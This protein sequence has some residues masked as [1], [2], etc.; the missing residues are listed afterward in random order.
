MALDYNVMAHSNNYTEVYLRIGTL[1]VSVRTFLSESRHNRKDRHVLG[2][3]TT[4]AHLGRNLRAWRPDM[5]IEKSLR[6]FRWD[7]PL[8][9]YNFLAMV[10]TWNFRN[11]YYPPCLFVA[12]FPPVVFSQDL[13][14]VTKIFCHSVSLRAVYTNTRK[15]EWL[16]SHFY[17]R[18]GY[19]RKLRFVQ[20]TNFL[21]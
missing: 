20:Q 6:V 14:V 2:Q 12:V 18:C 11:N 5:R 4:S 10:D 21:C 9:S 8:Y 16:D 17:Q 7:K 3:S 13:P 1:D 15:V 19:K